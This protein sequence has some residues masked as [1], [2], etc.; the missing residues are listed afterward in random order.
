M[1]PGLVVVLEPLG[2]HA[3]RVSRAE[4]QKP[5]QAL[6]PSGADLPLHVGISRGAPRLES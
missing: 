1:R 5:I 4:D 3:L 6:S 2:E